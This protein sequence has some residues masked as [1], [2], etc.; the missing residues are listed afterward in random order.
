MAEGQRSKR[1]LEESQG[2]ENSWKREGRRRWHLWTKY[3]LVKISIAL[4]SLMGLIN[5]HQELHRRVN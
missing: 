1:R 5:N 4:L 2:R 3:S